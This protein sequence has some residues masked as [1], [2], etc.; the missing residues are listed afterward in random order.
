MGGKAAMTFALE[1]PEMV[2]KLVVVD[3]SPRQYPERAIHT[4]VLSIMMSMDLNKIQSRAEAEAYIDSMLDDSRIRMFVMK[5]LYYKMQGQLAWRLNLEAINQSMD[6][7]FD[8]INS[9]ASFTGPTLF[10]KGGKSDYILPEDHKKISKLFPK[11]SIE[12]IS[13]ASHWVH[14]DAPDLLYQ[15]ITDFLISR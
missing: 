6:L 4:K 14:A 15:L 5:N 11:A 10:I 13:G 9:D 3:I 1:Y 8:A 12:N 2:N 7:L